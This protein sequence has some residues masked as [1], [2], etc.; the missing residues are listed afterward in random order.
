MGVTVSTMSIAVDRLERQGY[1]TRARAD[2]DARVRHR[3]LT[4]AG[5]RFA[6][7]TKVLDPAL[8]RAMLSRLS[9]CRSTRRLR[10]LEL[11]GRS[12]TGAGPERARRRFARRSPPLIATVHHEETSHALG[13]GSLAFSSSCVLVVVVGYALP[14]AHV[15]SVSRGTQ[16]APTRSGAI[17]SDVSR[18]PSGGRTSRASS[19]FPM[20]T[21]SAA[22]ASTARTT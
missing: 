10:G 1:V 2:T 7:R 3:G 15:A 18:F 22:G 19:C 13:L 21:A 11:L 4:A 9:S 5:E 16:R 8:V 17:L 12:R 20:R 6:P 14:K